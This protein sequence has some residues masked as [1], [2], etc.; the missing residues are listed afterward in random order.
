MLTLLQNMSDYTIIT[1]VRG[2]FFAL[3]QNKDSNINTFRP[4]V[5]RALDK[6]VKLLMIALCK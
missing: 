5:M 4:L 3:K 1:S 6:Y 2:D